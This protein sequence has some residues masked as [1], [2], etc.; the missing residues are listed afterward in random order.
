MIPRSPLGRGRKKPKGG[1]I[2]KATGT[3][4]LTKPK[5]KPAAQK[6]TVDQKGLV[7]LEKG[8]PTEAPKSKRGTISETLKELRAMKARSKER[9]AAKNTKKPSTRAQRLLAQAKKS[10][11]SRYRRR[12]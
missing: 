7:H 1:Y 8:T 5:K 9:Q 3:P 10:K 2:T 11:Q 6:A 4:S 12:S